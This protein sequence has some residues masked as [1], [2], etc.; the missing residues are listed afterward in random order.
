VCRSTLAPARPGS[1]I[2]VC[3]CAAWATSPLSRQ[4]LMESVDFG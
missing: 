4:T 2:V 3:A 1:K